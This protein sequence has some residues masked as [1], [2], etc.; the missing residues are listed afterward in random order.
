MPDFGTL[1]V[2]AAIMHELPRG[3]GTSES[4]HGCTLTEAPIEFG[5]T[6]QGF[7]ELKLR[8]G[9]G[10]FSREVIED[11]SEMSK[12]P[13]MIRSL[14][15]SKSLEVVNPSRAMAI[16]LRCRQHAVTPVSLM[17]VATAS[18]DGEHAL[19]IAKLEHEQA[20]RVQPSVNKQGRRT[21]TAEHIRDLVLGEG[22][23][24]FKAAAFVASAASNDQPLRG[25]VID[26]QRTQG[27]V[28]DY[29]LQFLGC[30]FI[31]EP[32]VLTQRFFEVTEASIRSLTRNDPET[33]AN[34]EISLLAEMQA[35]SSSISPQNFAQRVMKP[36]DQDAYMQD[37]REA[38][39][40][41]R[42]ISKDTSL[43]ANMIRRVRVQTA[44]DATIFV[45]PDMYEDGSLSIEN[46]ASGMSR[47]TIEDELRSVSGASGSRN[48]RAS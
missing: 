27:G 5:A 12:T 33:Q 13:G 6:D 45:P 17:L 3:R 30:Q 19:V 43:V 40:P 25:H 18:I 35:Q 1:L 47:I 11:D 24:L 44:R 4:D 29:F 34:Y 9:L 10:G 46:L 26:T 21:Y 2:K 15:A 23:Q 36:E 32:R 48:A 31:Q 28:A 39:L 42:R 16:D 7:L 37:I 14:L 20:M 8:E 38:G 22:T 41:P